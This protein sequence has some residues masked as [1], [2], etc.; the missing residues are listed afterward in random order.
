MFPVECVTRAH[1]ERSVRELTASMAPN[2]TVPSTALD[3]RGAAADH[4][5]P[6]TACDRVRKAG[7]TP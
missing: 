6:A 1:D 3:R 5:V 2:A 7:S 4:A